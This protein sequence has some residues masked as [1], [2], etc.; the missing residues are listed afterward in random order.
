MKAYLSGGMENAPELGRAWRDEMTAWLN[1]Q[2]GHTVF[3]P[4]EIQNETL[5]AEEVENFRSWRF[6]QRAKFKLTVRKLI[7]RDLDAIDNEIDYVICN[8]DETVLKGGGTHGEVTMAYWLEKPEY[9]V[10][11]LPI[12]DISSWIF[13]C[14]D[15][16]FDN[17]ESLKKRFSVL[18]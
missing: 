2:L 8:W 13:S 1:N 9:Q 7:K 16:I 3:N 17:F 18:F 11:N 15:E 4:V 12:N 6:N 5:T 10:N 14:S